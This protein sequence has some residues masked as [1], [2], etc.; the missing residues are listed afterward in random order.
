MNIAFKV[1]FDC[2][3]VLSLLI[4]F[5][6]FQVIGVGYNQ[7]G[8]VIVDGDVVY[9]FYNLVVSRIVEVKLYCLKS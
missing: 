8:E 5:Y 6:V 2:Y 7:F 3:Q 4:L 1:L 9:G